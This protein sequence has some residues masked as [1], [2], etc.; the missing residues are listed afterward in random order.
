MW[1]VLGLYVTFKD[2]RWIFVWLWLLGCVS[3]VDQ[4]CLYVGRTVCAS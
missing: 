2:S 4:S 3:I 1:G